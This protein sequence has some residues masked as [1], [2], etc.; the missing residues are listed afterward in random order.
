M[1]TTGIEPV[2]P[3]LESLY[4]AERMAPGPDDATRARLS[5]R[6]EASLG[7]PLGALPRRPG[8]VSVASG[9]AAGGWGGVLLVV[10]AF[11][12]AGIVAV[13]AGFL[14]SRARTHAPARRLA[15]APVTKAP[16][17]RV[18]VPSPAPAP[19]PAAH[20]QPATDLPKAQVPESAPHA[21]AAR[22]TR[23]PATSSL[24]GEEALIDRA[25]RALDRGRP[26]QALGALDAHRARYPNGRL[27]EEREAL[28]VL[29][30]C[31]EGRAAAARR[32]G[33]RFARRYPESL[34][35]PMVER[36]LATLP[37]AP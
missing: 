3:L 33:S 18:A 27:A 21:N 28:R 5:A 35:R 16:V 13:G 11:V 19:S 10:A 26:E 22:A 7:A 14:V 17:P 36:A 12:G 2:E 24:A 32:V 1:S 9:G 29:A 4:A 31:R 15:A 6:L 30:L 37:S 34:F 20:P 8:P 23:R 25:H